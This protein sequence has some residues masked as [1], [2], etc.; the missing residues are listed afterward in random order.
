MRHRGSRPMPRDLVTPLED[1]WRTALDGVARERGFASSDEVARVGRSV[2]RLSALYNDRSAKAPEADDRDALAARL[3]FSFVRDVPKG[4]GAVRELA[5]A[6]LLSIDRPLRVLDVGAGLGAM[7]WGIARAV[8]RVHATSGA[9][10]A[11]IPSIEADL[12][13]H[14]RG[15]L[16]LAEAIARA[17]GGLASRDGATKVTLRTRVGTADPSRTSSGSYDVV[18]LGQ[19]LSELDRDATDEER[20]KRHEGLVRRWL[21]HVRPDGSLVIVEPALRDR[22]RHLHR[23][24]DSLLGLAEAEVT[25]QPQPRT[26]PQV[27]VFA[28]CLHRSACPMLVREHDWC[29][30]DLPIDLPE[31]LVP[32]ARAAGLRFQGLTFSYLVLRRDGVSLGTVLTAPSLLRDVSGLRRTKG[33]SERILCGRTEGLESGGGL[34]AMRLDRAES[35]DNAIW[36][37]AERGDV[38][39]FEPPLL[40]ERA[41]IEKDTVVGVALD[42]DATRR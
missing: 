20:V 38:L 7:T 3:V 35:A 13:D 6:G 8:G 23:L 41:R 31:W 32:I 29:H 16:D 9:S 21:E 12:V 1:D 36:D 28:P 33:K 25:G 11:P 17:R 2:E 26:R 10:G 14:H 4:A 27:G 24:R 18:V 22:S 30:E 19:V 39:G 5:R 42:D 34:R 40:R 37:H 15:A